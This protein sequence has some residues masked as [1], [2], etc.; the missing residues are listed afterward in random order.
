[1][2]VETTNQLEM[3]DEIYSSVVMEKKIQSQTIVKLKEI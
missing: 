3:E 2:E 1:V